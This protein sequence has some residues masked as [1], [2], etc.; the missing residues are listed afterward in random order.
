[1]KNPCTCTCKE[2]NQE[3]EKDVDK[4]ECIQQINKNKSKGAD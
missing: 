4:F 2:A 3:E 1:M